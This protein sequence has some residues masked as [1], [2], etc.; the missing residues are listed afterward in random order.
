MSYFTNVNGP[1][2]VVSTDSSSLSVKG[3][4][5]RVRKFS[6]FRGSVSADINSVEI[7]VN[8]RAIVEA[9]GTSV[10]AEDQV[11]L[12]ASYQTVQI[13]RNVPRII[14]SVDKFLQDPNF[15]VNTRY[16]PSDG[17]PDL[18][19]KE[20]VRTALYHALC[21]IGTDFQH[22]GKNYHVITTTTD[23]AISGISASKVI[24]G[25]LSINIKGL[26]AESIEPAKELSILVDPSTLGNAINEVISGLNISISNGSLY[27]RGIKMREWIRS[28]TITVNATDTRLSD[29]KINL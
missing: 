17:D 20:W 26:D 1:Q 18:K 29:V 22:N 23:Y 9:D 28:E 4:A 11:N 16:I 8:S 24:S 27:I 19:A 10:S 2:T 7:N 25:L 6:H 15:E 21:G 3:Q 13:K 5:N 12:L 14:E